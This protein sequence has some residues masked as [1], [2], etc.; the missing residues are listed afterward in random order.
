MSSNGGG[1]EC[2]GASLG[3]GEAAP[4]LLAARGTGAGYGLAPLRGGQMTPSQPGPPRSFGLF[5]HL[6]SG[7]L[8]LRLVRRSS[9]M[10]P[11]QV[12]HRGM[13]SAAAAGAPEPAVGAAAG[14][15]SRG[16]Q[17]TPSHS[18]SLHLKSGAFGLRLPTRLSHMSPEHFGQLGV[19]EAESVSAG[20]CCSV[21]VTA[22]ATVGRCGSIRKLVERLEKLEG[23]I[24]KRRRR[25]T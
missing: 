14:L 15:A 8:G 10:A 11:P 16:G 5:L 24:V 13:P 7:A 17:I 2:G 20:C 12:G 25:A 22:G 4:D 9:H 19:G 3:G 6:K 1:S 18:R 23:T 21:I